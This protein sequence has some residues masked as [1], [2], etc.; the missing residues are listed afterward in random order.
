MGFLLQIGDV[1]NETGLS[2]D[3]IRFYERERLLQKAARSSGGFRLFSSEDVADLTFIRNAQELGFSL[4]EIRDLVG[5]RKTRHPDCAKVE[6]MLGHKIAAVRAKIYALRTLERELQRTLNH[7][8]ANLL[9]AANGN[10]EDCPVLVDI[11]RSPGRK[12]E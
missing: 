2:V 12:R 3:T 5:V 1:A 11:S 10:A 8:Q 4:Q 9:K 6:K 7:C